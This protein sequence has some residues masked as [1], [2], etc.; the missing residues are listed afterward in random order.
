M[1]EEYEKVYRYGVQERQDIFLAYTKTKGSLL[2]MIDFVPY[3][4]V[5][6]I[7]R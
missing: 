2:D 1:I 6:D 4:T 3:S 5:N 7:K